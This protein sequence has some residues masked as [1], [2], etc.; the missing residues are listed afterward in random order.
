MKST[1]IYKCSLLLNHGMGGPFGVYMGT[2][3]TLSWVDH[4][5]FCHRE[6]LQLQIYKYK[7][8]QMG[9]LTNLKSILKVE[10]SNAVIITIKK[11]MV[12]R[13]FSRDAFKHHQHVSVTL[14]S[15][16]VLVWIWILGGQACK[17]ISLAHLLN[18]N[19]SIAHDQSEDGP[20]SNWREKRN[21]DLKRLRV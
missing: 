2:Q 16:Y 17:T 21:G 4:S 5:I 10:V 14:S 18:L 7:A 15:I 13:P 11:K 8:L 12:Q 3:S 19:C 6:W 1:A 9:K 20:N